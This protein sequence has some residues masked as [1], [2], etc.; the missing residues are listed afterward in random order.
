MQ[1]LFGLEMC[2]LCNTTGDK[3]LNSEL[4]GHDST[5]VSSSPIFFKDRNI[6]LSRVMFFSLL[7]SALP[8]INITLA[9]S[10]SD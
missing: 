5:L 7:G 8:R 1:R 9:I 10:Q 4:S 3:T 2:Y 6:L